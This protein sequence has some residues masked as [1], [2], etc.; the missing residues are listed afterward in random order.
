M[1][2][3][4]TLPTSDTPPHWHS[5]LELAASRG[6]AVQLTVIHGGR[7]V[8]NDSVRCTRDALGWLFS[9][10]K[11]FTSLLVHRLAATGA[12][13]LDD[14]VARHWPEYGTGGAGT[15]AQTTIRDVLTHRTGLPTAGPY[16]RAVLTMQDAE[17]SARRVASARRRHRRFGQRPDG[18]PDGAA[19][20]SAVAAYQPLD[21]GIILGRVV[22][23]VTG[24]PWAQALR[25][26]VLDPMSLADVHPGVPEEQLR[27]CLPVD[28]SLRALPGGPVVARIVNRRSV[29]Q[30][31]IPAAGISTTASQLAHFYAQL[32]HAPELPELSR[33]SS[34]GGRDAWTRLETRWGTGV[35]LGGTGRWC[36]LGTTSTP[37]AVGHNGSD[38]CLGWADPDLEL[39]VGLI[40]DRASGSAADKR[41]LIELSDLIRSL[42]ANA[43]GAAEAPGA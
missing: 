30:A 31:V 41:V 26:L 24:M 14:P 7:T 19:S 25:D 17:S 6:A 16:A 40:T 1:A 36:P 21:F 35:Q 9:A 43:P 37:R 12:L 34:D 27:R 39:A 38:V 33:P 11:P 32:L 10:G 28:G 22:Q 29:R 5:A 2:P 20:F 42:A 23:E 13:Q 15:K 3:A 18:S 8:L 4:R